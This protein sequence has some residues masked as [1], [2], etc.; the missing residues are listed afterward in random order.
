MPLPWFRST[1][2][3]ILTPHASFIGCAVS[4]LHLEFLVSDFSVTHHILN[5]TMGGAA[6]DPH[7]RDAAK[8]RSFDDY[9]D[10][11]YLSDK[12]RGGARKW[13]AKEVAERLSKTHKED[14][15][16]V[17]GKNVEHC[18]RKLWEGKSGLAS[19]SRL[20]SQRLQLSFTEDHCSIFILS[21]VTHV[22]LS[23]DHGR[24][25]WS[26]LHRGVRGR[27]QCGQA[28][29]PAGERRQRQR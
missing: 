14:R 28:L 7:N 27:P 6:P 1:H 29:L 8:W 2:I 20:A 15:Y 23:S 9:F 12:L 17:S 10:L 19:F 16:W 21:C 5:I 13:D 3:L 18:K 4:P 11:K 22:K 25:V 26:G 24:Q